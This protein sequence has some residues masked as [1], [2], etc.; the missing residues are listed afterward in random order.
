MK[1]SL[2][3]SIPGFV[4]VHGITNITFQFVSEI[5][6]KLYGD[7]QGFAE[8]IDASGN[9]QQANIIYD[10]EAVGSQGVTFLAAPNGTLPPGTIVLQ[11][12]LCQDRDGV[13][14]NN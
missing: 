9:I 7:D 14:M 2:K 11:R 1:K 10:T 6:K 3:V 13:I 4:E 8:L 5:T 12:K